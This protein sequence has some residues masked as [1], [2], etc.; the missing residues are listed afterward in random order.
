MPPRPPLSALEAVRKT[1]ASVVG[2]GGLD[3]Q[4]LSKMHIVEACQ[5]SGTVV[6]EMEV[7]KHHLNRVGGLHGGTTCTL[8]DIG[9]SLAIAARN[10]TM[11]TG[12]SADLH[13]SFLNGGKLGDKLRIHS[14]CHK[15]GRTL[16][17]TTVEIK[18][19]DKTIATGSHTKFV[20]NP[21]KD[22]NSF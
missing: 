5:K 18:S 7:E 3:T 13:V 10:G 17:F 21:P 6:C 8:T 4:I 12:V 9:G 2:Y 22:P 11:Y 15:S 14:T 16:A 19:G 1:W 20:G